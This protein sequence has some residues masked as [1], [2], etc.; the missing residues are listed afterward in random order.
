MRRGEQFAGMSLSSRAMIAE[1]G[2][3]FIQ[4][5]CTVLI[6]GASRVVNALVMKAAESK[7]FNIIVTESRPDGSG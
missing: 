2:H 6:H 1:L 7:H 3:S 5:N 4:D